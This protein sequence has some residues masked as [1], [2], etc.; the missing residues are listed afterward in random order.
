MVLL[1]RVAAHTAVPLTFAGVAG[2]QRHAG[3]RDP[4]PCRRS[5]G[6][7]GHLGAGASLPGSGSAGG[8]EPHLGGSS[9][10]G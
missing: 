6:L 5:Q 4:A 8:Q 10:T 1:S 2:K 7:L 9:G 3:V